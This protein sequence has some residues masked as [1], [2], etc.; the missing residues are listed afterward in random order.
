MALLID[1]AMTAYGGTDWNYNE[2]PDGPHAFLKSESDIE[3]PITV[4]A[5][6]A[7]ALRKIENVK[8]GKI[9]VDIH[10]DVPE[11][12]NVAQI[13]DLIQ[14]KRYDALPVGVRPAQPLP[15]N[16]RLGVVVYNKQDGTYTVVKIFF[17][18]G[19]S[20]PMRILT[21]L[22]T[23]TAY[24]PHHREGPWA[25]KKAFQSLLDRLPGYHVDW[26]SVTAKPVVQRKGSQRWEV[27]NE[28]LRAGVAYINSWCPED[29]DGNQQWIWIQENIKESSGSPIADWPEAKVQKLADNKCKGAMAACPVQRWFPL[30]IFDLHPIWTVLAMI[31]SPLMTEYGILMLGLP[32]IGKTPTFLTLAMTMGRYWCRVRPGPGQPGFRRGRMFDNFKNRAAKV[33]EALFLDDPGL[34]S[35]DIADL[36]QFFDVGEDGFGNARYNP[37]KLCKNG[38]RGA[39][40]NEFDEA[41]EPAADYRTTISQE[42]GLKLCKK[43]FG[44]Q[45]MAHIM[46]VLKR[47]ITI[48]CGKHAAYLRLPSQNQDATVHRIMIDN[49]HIDWLLEQNKKYYGMYKRGVESYP[50]DYQENLE[51]E[52]EFVDAAMATRGEKKPEDFIAECN[53][54]LQTELLRLS[55]TPPSPVIPVRILPDSQDSPQGARTRVFPDAAGHYHFPLQ[56]VGS[57]SSAVRSRFKCVGEDRRVRRRTKSAPGE[58]VATSQEPVDMIMAGVQEQAGAAA[59][60]SQYS[61]LGEPVATSQEPGDMTMAS[62]QEQAGAAAS[63][64]RHSTWDGPHDDPFFG[65]DSADS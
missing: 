26:A 39:A 50:A 12:G 53:E 19:E 34:S 55:P 35:M 18:I 58:P 25:F 2:S 65:Q 28:E 60:D 45:G 44:Y 21:Q 52:K 29:T 40:D 1:E 24:V 46:A 47:T 14:N 27:P 64:S 59:S 23:G 3:A 7:G 5:F 13:K 11:F 16:V 49:F 48:I 43:P 6:I 63:D 17:V 62:V 51:K 8:R 4:Q 15:D 36:K 56:Q 61:A 30:L 42:E 57:A 22:A 41:D 9:V 32:G 31:L 37:A 38:M 10:D 54:K 20:M 33:C